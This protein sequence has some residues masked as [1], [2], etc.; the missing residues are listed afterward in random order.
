[1]FAWKGILYMH[2]TQHGKFNKH[3]FYP[4]L[5]IY[6]RNIK[7]KFKQKYFKILPGSNVCKKVEKRDKRVKFVSKIWSKDSLNQSK[8]QIGQG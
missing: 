2:P 3:Y 7:K 4:S 8:S 5:S 1:M 6:L